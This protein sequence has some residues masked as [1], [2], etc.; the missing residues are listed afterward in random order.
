MAIHL[1]RSLK[2]W[3]F[4]N[5]KNSHGWKGEDAEQVSRTMLRG[6]ELAREQINVVKSTSAWWRNKRQG[7]FFSC[8][9]SEPHPGSILFAYPFFFK[10]ANF[11]GIFKKHRNILKKKT[12]TESPLSTLSPQISL[13]FARG[14][15]L[16]PA[17]DHRKYRP[18][19]TGL[20]R[21]T[22]G[23]SGGLVVH[24]MGNSGGSWMNVQHSMLKMYPK[25]WKIEVKTEN[26]IFL[27]SAGACQNCA[28]ISS[29]CKDGELYF[30][31]H[32]WKWYHPDCVHQTLVKIANEPPLARLP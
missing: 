14:H 17:Y 11:R 26:C 32:H 9:C 28:T 21:S 2:T 22:G 29:G 8:S 4:R 10:I 16:S 13:A 19:G 18:N 12:S 25:F 5:F 30:E 1:K 27:K 20:P 6:A 24:A 23:W 31:L 7:R 15:L 3:L